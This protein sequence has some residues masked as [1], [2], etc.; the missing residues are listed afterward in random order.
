MDRPVYTTEER[1]EII[2]HEKLQTVSPNK[3]M[4][5]AP[6]NSAAGFQSGNLLESLIGCDSHYDLNERATDLERFEQIQPMADTVDQNSLC[7]ETQQFNNPFPSRKASFKKSRN[8]QKVEK[9]PK[10]EK[11]QKKK[12]PQK[13]QESEQFDSHNPRKG[14]RMTVPRSDSQNVTKSR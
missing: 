10:P 1:S 8:S 5:F 3:F 12:K 11:V 2:D 9:S 7:M 6:I 13:P 4:S 14:L